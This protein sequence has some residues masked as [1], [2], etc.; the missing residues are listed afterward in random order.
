MSQAFKPVN[1]YHG[2][3]HPDWLTHISP[4]RQLGTGAFANRF[5]S[6]WGCKFLNGTEGRP[7]DD[8]YDDLGDRSVGVI[9]NPNAS[10][11]EWANTNH[12][13]GVSIASPDSTASQGTRIHW[14]RQSI[15]FSDYQPMFMGRQRELTFAFVYQ[16]HAGDTATTNRVLIS[17]WS[18]GTGVNGRPS[19]PRADVTYSR[20]APGPFP[21]AFAMRVTNRVLFMFLTNDEKDQLE[22]E[23]V[24]LAFTWR[25]EDGGVMTSYFNG[26]Q[27]TTNVVGTS[28]LLGADW[29]ILGPNVGKQDVCPNGIY[30]QAMV[31]PYEWT[32]DHVAR[33]AQDPYGWIKPFQP[34]PKPDF[35]TLSAT[36]ASM[37]MDAPAAVASAAGT[38]TAA[39]MTLDAPAAVIDF[40][41]V[42]LRSDH[43]LLQTIRAEAD[44]MATI[45][46]DPKVTKTIQASSVFSKTIQADAT[47][48][49]RVQYEAKLVKTIS[50]EA[51]G[52]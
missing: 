26:Y 47:L 28:N 21:F 32:A 49:P 51:R 12:G 16:H 1:G 30:T 18:W 39:S 2:H 25:Y 45:S 36:A 14:E 35:I 29:I 13:L 24:P 11:N 42:K 22:A 40:H 23:P 17:A 44:V 27:K 46:A 3:C 4:N 6:G 9:Q 33:W 41:T 20:N 37:A 15:L 38:A 50:S 52:C 7:P 19:G 48:T 5:G 31:V 34:L 10:V 8:L 43:N